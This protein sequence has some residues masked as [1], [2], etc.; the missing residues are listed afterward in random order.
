MIFVTGTNHKYSPVE[1]RERISFPRNKI[2][3][4]VSLLDGSNVLSGGVILSTCNRTEIYAS[5]GNFSAGLEEV[6]EFLEFQHNVKMEELSRYFYTYR[7]RDTLTH[8]CYVVSGLDSFIPGEREVFSQVKDVFCLSQDIRFMD[9]FLEK[10]F[11]SAFS[12]SKKV[13]THTD[14]SKEKIS[15][16]SVAVAFIKEKLGGIRGKKILII[17]TGKVSSL[18]VRYLSKESPEVVFIANR[19]HEKAKQLAGIIGGQVFRFDY[20]KEYISKADVIITGTASPHFIIKKDHLKDIRT[21]KKLLILDLALPRDVDPDIG[22]M[23]NVELVTLEN[24]SSISEQNFKKRKKE[25]L[26]GEAII[27]EE[28]ERVWENLLRWEQDPVLSQ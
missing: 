5:A 19:T 21:E 28:V 18:I 2:A 4:A 9:S 10:V 24:L 15:I 25:A 20:I 13:H 12:I 6:F 14:L 26:K 11:H 22:K 23:S 17:G 27:K 1:I 3:L 16:G 7:E 8:L